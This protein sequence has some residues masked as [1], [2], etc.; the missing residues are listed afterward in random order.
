MVV[1]ISC[2]MYIL[3]IYNMENSVITKAKKNNFEARQ[4]LSFRK[5]GVIVLISA[6]ILIIALNLIRAILAH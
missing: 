2:H 5:P 3:D 4:T 1:R 6:I